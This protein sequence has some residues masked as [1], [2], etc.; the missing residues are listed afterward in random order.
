MTQSQMHTLIQLLEEE[1]GVRESCV[2]NYQNQCGCDDKFIITDID[3]SERALL[4]RCGQKLAKERDA[5]KTFLTEFAMTGTV[6]VE[7]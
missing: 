2:R 3:S 1:A 6:K 4:K 7:G 5:I